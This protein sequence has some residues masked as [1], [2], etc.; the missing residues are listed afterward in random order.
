VSD[1]KQI[2]SWVYWCLSL[3]KLANRPLFS[4]GEYHELVEFDI[5]SRQDSTISSFNGTLCKPKKGPSAV[6]PTYKPNYLEA[7]IT[8]IMVWGQSRQ[9]VSKIPTQQNKSGEG[10][11]TNPREQDHLSICL[12]S[13]RCWVQTPVSPKRIKMVT[14][15]VTCNTNI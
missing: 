15:I 11:I 10:H 1:R 8:R 5:N 9:K 14:F 7:E 12:A 2:F 13:V 4:N 3:R 6:V